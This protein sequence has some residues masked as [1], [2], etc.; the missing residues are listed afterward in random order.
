LNPA[1]R[2]DVPGSP[3]VG[4]IAKV[5]ELRRS[6][7]NVISLG[8]G[9]PSF[10]TPEHI[11][12]FA[13]K[14]LDDGNTFYSDSAGIIELRTAIAEKMEG[15]NGIKA[16]PNSEILVTVG[17]KEAIFTTMMAMIN[18]GD[19]VILSD[20]CWVSYEPC[21]IFAGG[22]PVKIPLYEDREFRLNV[23]D[24]EKSI[25][26]KTKLIIVNSPNNP[27]G[28]ML[29]KN[30]LQDIANVAV[31]NDLLVLS[32]ELYEYLAYDGMRHYSIASFPGMRDRTI[33]VNGFSK[34]FAM[35]GW[36]LGYMA[37]NKRIIE[38]AKVIHEHSVTAPST[39]AQRAAAL[40]LGDERSWKFV[41]EMNAQYGKRRDI[42][43]DGLTGINGVSC[44]KPRGAFY[45]F[46]NISSIEKS[47]VRMSELLLEKARV[48]TIPG[49]GFG[50]RGE[51]HIRLTF[52]N[53]EDELREAVQRIKETIESL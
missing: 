46:P 53:S 21:I 10:V 20:P 24:L 12:E 38:R 27:T 1:V 39:F 29:E 25:T 2:I 33:T 16:D 9:E 19:E 6:G 28:G 49:V 5:K 32:D 15:D 3:T 17:G 41:A 45:A 48:A 4:M 7:I 22:I 35:T 13:K 40:A 30:D 52:T 31:E 26:S 37:A 14:A 43:M 8:A 34:A 36:R 23:A 47:S 18:P 11:R 50:K 44:V 51:G 42:L